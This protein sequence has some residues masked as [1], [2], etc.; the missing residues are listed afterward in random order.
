MLERPCPVHIPLLPW[1]CLL[2]AWPPACQLISLN[3]SALIRKTGRKITLTLQGCYAPGIFHKSILYM[4]RIRST[5]VNSIT[6]TLRTVLFRQA[7]VHSNPFLPTHVG[8]R[9][10]QHFGFSLHYPAY[11]F[12]TTRCVHTRTP[13]LKAGQWPK[14]RG[15]TIYFVNFPLLLTL[16]L[17][18]FYYRA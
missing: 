4:V 12:F 16:F 17:V 8:F 5:W 1:L 3:L 14:G 11:G 6:E 2:G 9:P 15:S 7:K 18:T 10:V 13:L